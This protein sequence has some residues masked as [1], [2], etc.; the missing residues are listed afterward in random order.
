MEVKEVLA[1]KTLER[2]EKIS[3]ESAQRR[4]EEEEED[5]ETIKIDTSSS[6]IKLDIA[7]IHDLN[8]DSVK[9]NAPVLNNIEI[10]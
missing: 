2:L 6:N 7:D 10:L 8:K 3:A 4:K 9:L 1:P 5:E